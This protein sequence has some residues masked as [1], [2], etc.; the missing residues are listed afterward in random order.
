VDANVTRENPLE[1]KAF[2]QR[3]AI[4]PWRRTYYDRYGYPRG[5]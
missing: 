5:Y 4:Y 2:N 1:Q 3:R